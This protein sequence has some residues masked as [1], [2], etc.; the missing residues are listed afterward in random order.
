MKRQ[1]K[2]DNYNWF[3]PEFFDSK[4]AKDVA[5]YGVYASLFLAF[6][7]I[8]RIGFALLNTWKIEEYFTIL[9]LTIVLFTAYYMYKMKIWAAIFG[10]C[11]FTLLVLLV[12]FSGSNPITIPNIVAL[13]AYFNTIRATWFYRK[14]LK[15][16]TEKK[17]SLK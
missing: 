1:N 11:Y 4:S 14:L 16:E 6:I 10:F 2:R 15:K 8:L 12:L 7:L 5:I 9:D 17:D 13:L 3:N